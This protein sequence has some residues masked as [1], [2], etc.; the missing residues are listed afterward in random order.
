MIPADASAHLTP[1]TCDPLRRRADRGITFVFI[2]WTFLLVTVV[3]VQVFPLRTHT[4]HVASLL[5]RA[6]GRV[7]LKT[8]QHL[9]CLF[10][11]KLQLKV[12]TNE[13]YQASLGGVLRN[14]KAVLKITGGNLSIGYRWVWGPITE[15]FEQCLYVITWLLI[16]L[17]VLITYFIN[18]QFLLIWSELPRHTTSKWL[19]IV[20]ICL[21]WDQI[22]F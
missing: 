9:Y 18:L 22:F 5:P 7:T 16:T 17:R 12:S 11:I 13:Q 19:K 21:I 4:V 2:F 6:T 20:H 8:K 15:E 10:S 3:I 14:V 1:L